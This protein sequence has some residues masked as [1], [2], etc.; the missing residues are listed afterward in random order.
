MFKDDF[1]KNQMQ[2]ANY[3]MV[4]VDD[5]YYKKK[6]GTNKIKNKIFDPI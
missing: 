2:D 6:L 1:S 3:N 4:N 5:D